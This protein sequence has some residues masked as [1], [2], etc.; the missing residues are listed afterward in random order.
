MCPVLNE[1]LKRM[2]P[3]VQCSDTTMTLKV[4][5]VRTP[6]FLVESGGFHPNN[7]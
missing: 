4:K 3:S 2:D 1:K 5:G 6:H 7:P